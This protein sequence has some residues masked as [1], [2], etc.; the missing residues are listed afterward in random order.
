MS[1]IKIAVGFSWA[2]VLL[3]GAPLCAQQTSATE[4]KKSE[5]QAVAVLKRAAT[6]LAQA[7]SFSVT[8]DAGF[9]AV[10]ESGQKIEFGEIRKVVLRRPDRLRIDA[11][12]RDGS[13]TGLVFDG[14]EI[15]VF[16]PKE[17]VYA[18]AAQPGSI[19]QAVAFLVNDLDVRLPLAEL[20]NSNVDKSLPQRVRSAAYVEQSSIGGV[21]CDHVAFRS[22]DVDVQLWL[23]RDKQPLPRRVVITYKLT[24]GRPQYWAN[25]SDWNLSPQARDSLFSYQP[26]KDAAKIAFSP[27]Q[28]LQPAE[29][30]PNGR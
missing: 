26:S 3:A 6:F 9:D 21:P 22:D 28:M 27:R 29:I 19:D 15:T 1:R 16:H 13:T 2:L 14:K 30:A 18:T 11:T 8:I 4:A 20:L 12:K 23:T 5:E 25:F 17:N 7:K 10:Q 24:D